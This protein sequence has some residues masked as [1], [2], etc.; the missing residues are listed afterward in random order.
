M[1]ESSITK[2][3]GWN[4]A[5][6]VVSAILAIQIGAFYLI[7]SQELTPPNPN[8]KDLPSQLQ[9]WRM[10]QES[11]VEQEVMEV[12]KADKTLSR[13]YVDSS[14]QTASLFVAFFRT[15]RAGVSPH[16]PK[17]CLP[18]SGWVPVNSMIIPLAVP[19]MDAPIPVN[20]YTIAKGDQKSVVLYWYQSHNRIVA[21][22][23]SAKFYTILD[24]IRYRRSDTSLVRVL[25]PVADG[26]EGEAQATA[27]QFVRSFFSP[28]R[29]QLPG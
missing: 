13:M 22:E 9:T 5:L 26:K 3:I 20:R 25:V 16:S 29:Q 8:L 10:V 19:G 6:M 28:L 7:P 14:N 23:Y 1:Q 27:E 24:S 21:S 11:E 15:Q 17:V 2:H 18:G 4:T 12:L